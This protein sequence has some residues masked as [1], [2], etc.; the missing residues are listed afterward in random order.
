MENNTIMKLSKPEE[1]FKLLSEK[2]FDFIG[3]FIRYFSYWKWFVLSI[4]IC[5]IIAI[6]NVK[7]SLPVYKVE[8]SVLKVFS[9][10]KISD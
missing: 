9:G 8:T 3:L 6:L 4:I 5:L 7:F 10:C 2:S 1:E